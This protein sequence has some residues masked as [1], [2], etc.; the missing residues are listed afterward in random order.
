MSRSKWKGPYTNTGYLDNSNKQKPHSN[1]IIANRNSEIIPKFIGQT[2]Q[3]HNGKSYTEI[4]VTE[5][6]VNHKF[7]EFIFTRGIFSFKKKKSKK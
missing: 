7:G 4:T 6:M 5:D 1:I 3:V 2:F